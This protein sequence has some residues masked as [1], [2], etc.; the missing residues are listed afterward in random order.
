MCSGARRVIAK[1]KAVVILTPSGGGSGAHRVSLPARTG[2][3]PPWVTHEPSDVSI[4][5]VVLT[6]PAEPVEGTA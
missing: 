4:P 1:G 5:S 6:V 2:T 3:R